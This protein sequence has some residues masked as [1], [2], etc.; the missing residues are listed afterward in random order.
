MVDFTPALLRDIEGGATLSYPLIIQ[1]VTGLSRQITLRGRSLPFRGVEFPSELRVNTKYFPG[2]PIG[3]AQ[4]LGATWEDTLITGRWADH[5]IG[6]DFS[7]PKLHN[8][9]PL[10]FGASI[11]SVGGSS[12]QSAGTVP[13]GSVK[14]IRVLIDAFYMLQRGGS[15]LKVSWGQIARYG[16]IKR[17]APSFKRVDEADWEIEFTWI[18]DTDAPQKFATTSPDPLGLLQQAMRALQ[19][20]LNKMNEAL[21]F[22]Y[23]NVLRVT[24]LIRKVGFLITSFIDTVN[25]FANLLFVPAQIFGTVMQQ[26]AS[27]KTA[28]QDLVATLRSVPAAYSAKKSGA[29]QEQ[30]NEA[31]ELIGTILL[32]ALQLGLDIQEI[33]DRLAGAVGDHLLG[34]VVTQSQQTL[35]DIARQYYGS[36]DAWT[37]IADYNG[38]SGSLVPAGSVIRVP[39]SK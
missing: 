26:I 5:L 24:Q 7:S 13:E 22:A 35:R 38:I 36:S 21:L 3:Q 25:G 11:G 37:I 27:I 19:E 33:A 23:G 14:K 30:V 31:E 12:F 6:D 39:R 17:F 1:E 4:V 16:F 9:P 32:N 20:F 29:N 34:I 10:S 18:G 2:N 15:L 28:I 8:F